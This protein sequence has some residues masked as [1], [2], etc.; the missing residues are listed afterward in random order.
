MKRGYDLDLIYD[1]ARKVD[2]PIIACGGAGKSQDL[3]DVVQKGHADAVACAS[4][5]H[6]KLA[7][8]ADVK[9]DLNQSQIL[10]RCA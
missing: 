2:V 8:I 10:V 3:V 6:Y 5:F 4:L 9:K 1:I 7:N